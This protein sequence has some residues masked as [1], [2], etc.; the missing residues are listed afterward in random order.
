M[1]FMP[2][3]RAKHNKVTYV[4]NE[5][6]HAGLRDATPSEDLDSVRRGELC[7]ART[8]RLQERYLTSQLA[9]LLLV[10]LSADHQQLVQQRG[11]PQYAPC[12]TSGT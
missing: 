1:S 5:A 11:R 12:C 2:F 7:T 4:L 9:R 3:T 10:R 6:T 8:V